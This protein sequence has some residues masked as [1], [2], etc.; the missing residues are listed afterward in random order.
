VSREGLI[1]CVMKNLQKIAASHH[2][3][4]K[5]EL[6]NFRHFQSNFIEA[7][8]FYYYLPKIK[9]TTEHILYVFYHTVLAKFKRV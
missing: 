7:S 5:S 3:I 1:G 6:A 2:L 4:V 8:K 9:D